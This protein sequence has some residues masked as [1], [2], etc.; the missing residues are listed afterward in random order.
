MVAIDF[1]IGPNLM[2]KNSVADTFAVKVIRPDTVHDQSFASA[3]VLF[4][5][6]QP[7][8]IQ[9]QNVQQIELTLNP[10]KIAVVLVNVVQKIIGPLALYEKLWTREKKEENGKFNLNFFQGIIIIFLVLKY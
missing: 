7:M 2:V 4:Q 6:E 5:A 10:G 1:A 8:P 3:D 9:T